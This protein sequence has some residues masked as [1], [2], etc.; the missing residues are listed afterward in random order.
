M[1][2]PVANAG[3]DELGAPVHNRGYQS[4]MPRR[5]V[6]IEDRESLS[7]WSRQAGHHTK[8]GAFSLR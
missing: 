3:V 6:P 4:A 1:S 2:D 7:R 5:V 8:Y